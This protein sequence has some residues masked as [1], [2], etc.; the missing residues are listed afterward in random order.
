MTIRDSI[1]AAIPEGARE[2]YYRAV[3]GVTAFL[4]AFGVL[5]NQEAALWTQLGLTAVTSLFAMLYSTQAWRTALYAIVGPLG[6]VLMA[7]GIVADVRW[8]LITAAVGQLF[9]ITTMAAKTVQ[10]P[11]SGSTSPPLAA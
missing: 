5:D 3:A 11:T 4:L 6:S 2:A 1:R 9:G 7:Y 8:A 10:L